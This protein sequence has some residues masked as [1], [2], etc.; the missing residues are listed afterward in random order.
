MSGNPFR[1]QQASQDG[2]L[3]GTPSA[4]K[5]KREPVASVSLVWTPNKKSTDKP[6]KV[7][8]V[9]PV[10]S[11]QEPP[12]HPRFPSLEELDDGL[13]S[14]PPR[15]LA[16]EPEAV[17]TRALLRGDLTAGGAID[18]KANEREEAA[19]AATSRMQSDFHLSQPPPGRKG[20]PS[21]P[22]ARTSAGTNEERSEQGED[23]KSKQKALMNVEAFKRLL[24]TGKSDT[25][26]ASEPSSLRENGN[27]TDSS[28]TSKRSLS[29]SGRDTRPESPDSSAS[30]LEDASSEEASTE[31]EDQE[32]QKIAESR[33]RAAV[34]ELGSLPLDK[35]VPQIVSFDDFD[36]ASLQPSV[37]EKAPSIETMQ[38]ALSSSDFKSEGSRQAPLPP[39]PMFTIH[40]E[41]QT[42]RGNIPPPRPNSR[43]QGQSN[44]GLRSRN[45]SNVDSTA[46][47]HST[48]VVSTDA[49]QPNT[50]P[51]PPPP[52][53]A[54]APR[55]IEQESAR[56]L[57]VTESID[58]SPSDDSATN[59]VSD[60]LE[61]S[62]NPKIR[63]PPPPT[64]HSS[65][66]SNPPIGR[67]PS[68][69]SISVARRLSPAMAGAA[70]PPPPPRRG[71]SKRTSYD[72]SKLTG[73]NSRRSSGHSFG[74]ER[75]DS[76]S[77][78]R[79]AAEEQATSMNKTEV[80][81]GA[82]A[83][84]LADLDAFQREVDALRARALGGR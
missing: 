47:A 32:D 48:A 3:G 31:E 18:L 46:N 74:T 26:Q 40:P 69:S 49:S 66:P 81:S 75:R 80:D 19:S 83:D 7:Q 63:P 27:S 34:S 79:R 57:S 30:S 67:T 51:K 52:P 61:I 37:E 15:G 39:S 44:Q 16:D 23:D 33:P 10:A 8:F 54:P 14:P 13:K 65:K 9:S 72:G 84:M 17:N 71:D 5:G 2:S 43:R 78:L 35:N 42:K 22:F 41:S 58:S 53:R 11:P 50:A 55:P 4:V 62:S 82:N 1:K 45:G 64:R 56:T 12:S 6:K 77:S 25:S 60:K 70:P 21:N 76:V 36:E 24:L 28:F 68:S 20:A 29:D 38:P 59:T 73:D